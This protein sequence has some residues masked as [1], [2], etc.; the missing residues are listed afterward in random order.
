M[1][2]FVHNVVCDKN[3][4]AGIM[5]CRADTWSHS[6]LGYVVHIYCQE[7][8]WAGLHLAMSYHQSLL[9]HLD[10]TDAGFAYRSDIGILGAA[11]RI[12]FNHHNISNIYINNS[13][14]MGVQVVHQSLLYHALIPN[15]T[16]ST[17]V[18]D[19]VH[20]GSPS[21]T[22]MNAN[23]IENKGNGFVCTSTWDQTNTFAMNMASS[24][25]YKIF[26]LCSNNVT[27]LPANRVY[28][29]VLEKLDPTPRQTCQHVMETKPGYK[30]VIQELYYYNSL[31]YHSNFI[32]IYDGVNMSTGSSWK[33]KRSAWEYPPVF[34]STGPSVL[35]N[36]KN[37]YPWWSWSIKFLV[38]TVEGEWD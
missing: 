4:D 32:D 10:I 26:H 36:F 24:D 34:N 13:A 3:A 1:N 18:S 33:M 20:Y 9:R 7:G 19:G 15:S 5:D 30:L 29:F 22:L 35:F 17:T 38:Y 8:N 12:D 21:L 6:C 31:S 2:A 37:D 25:V 23:I 16:I 27:F 14:G 28:Y 11:L